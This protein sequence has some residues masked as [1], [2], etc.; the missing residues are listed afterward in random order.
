MG[1][2]YMDR[3]AGGGDIT[4]PHLTM[5]RQFAKVEQDENV[6][7]VFTMPQRSADERAAMFKAF[8]SCVTCQKSL[9]GQDDVKSCAKCE[10][11]RYC[12]TACQKRDAKHACLPCPELFKGISASFAQECELL[13]FLLPRIAQQPRADGRSSAP[14]AAFETL[15]EDILTSFGNVIYDGTLLIPEDAPDVNLHRDVQ[16]AVVPTFLRSFVDNVAFKKIITAVVD[17]ACTDKDRDDMIQSEERDPMAYYMQGLQ[18]THIAQL[19]DL[20][21]QH[22]AENYPDDEAMKLTAWKEVALFT[23]RCVAAFI[24]VDDPAEIVASGANMDTFAASLRSKYK[25]L[26]DPTLTADE[27]LKDGVRPASSVSVEEVVDL[28]SEASAFED[29]SDSSESE[30]MDAPTMPDV[31]AFKARSRAQYGGFVDNVGKVLAYL[32]KKKESKADQ[33]RARR[34]SLSSKYSDGPK[35]ITECMSLIAEWAKKEFKYVAFDVIGFVFVAFLRIGFT[36]LKVSTSHAAIWE[37]NTNI[38]NVIEPLGDTTPVVVGAYSEITREVDP[39]T[40]YGGSNRAEN[41]DKML[42]TVA[43][44]DARQLQDVINTPG[45][46]VASQDQLSHWFFSPKISSDAVIITTGT[47]VQTR[48]VRNNIAPAFAMTMTDLA[49][50][51]A[52][53]KVVF[54]KDV[55]LNPSFLYPTIMIMTIE[56][57]HAWMRLLLQCCFQ[58]RDASGDEDTLLIDQACRNVAMDIKNL[59]KMQPLRIQQEIEAKVYTQVLRDIY[60]EGE[61]LLTSETKLPFLKGMT[62]YSSNALIRTAIDDER[63]RLIGGTSQHGQLRQTQNFLLSGRETS[64]VSRMFTIINQVKNTI[65]RPRSFNG[66]NNSW[67]LRMHTLSAVFDYAVLPAAVSASVI[68]FAYGGTIEWTLF[69]LGLIAPITG[70]FGSTLK[71]YTAYLYGMYETVNMA[72]AIPA[73]VKKHSTAF[74]FIAY[75]GDNDIY[76][77]VIVICGFLGAVGLKWVM[78]KYW[79]SSKNEKRISA[80]LV[81]GGIKVV[82]KTIGLSHLFRFTNWVFNLI[83]QT[84]IVGHLIWAVGAAMALNYSGVFSPTG[85]S[86]WLGMSSDAVFLPAMNLVMNFS[87]LLALGAKDTWMYVP[88]L[89]AGTLK[90]AV[91]ALPAFKAN[92]PNDMLKQQQRRLLP[93][94]EKKKKKEEKE[95]LRSMPTDDVTIAEWDALAAD[96]VGTNALFIN[97]VC[98]FFDANIEGGGA[99]MRA[100][101]DDISIA[102]TDLLANAVEYQETGDESLLPD[103]RLS[104]VGPP[105]AVYVRFAEAARALAVGIS[106][107]INGQRLFKTDAD[108]PAEAVPISAAEQV[109]DRQKRELEDILMAAF[110][111]EEDDDTSEPTTFDGK[112]KKKK[113]PQNQEKLRNREKWQD[114]KDAIQVAAQ[115]TVVATS[116]WSSVKAFVM[117]TLAS[118]FV[119]QAAAVDASSIRQEMTIN[120][121]NVALLMDPQRVSGVLPGMSRIYDDVLRLDGGQTVFKSMGEPKTFADLTASFIRRVMGQQQTWIRRELITFSDDDQPLRELVNALLDKNDAAFAKA[122][123]DVATYLQNHSLARAIGKIIH[124][125]THAAFP[126]T[127]IN[128]TTPTNSHEPSAVVSALK[129]EA[130]KAAHQVNTQDAWLFF[131]KIA[132]LFDGSGDLG[133]SRGYALWKHTTDFLMVGRLRFSARYQALAQQGDWRPGQGRRLVLNAAVNMAPLVLA[134]FFNYLYGGTW[135]SNR[136]RNILALNSGV[137]IYTDFLAW[138][139][140]TRHRGAR[141]EKLMSME[142]FSAIHQFQIMHIKRLLPALTT[143]S[144]QAVTDN[145]LTGYSWA[146]ASGVGIVATSVASSYVCSRL[147][148]VIPD[149]YV[150]AESPILPQLAR[151]ALYTLPVLVTPTGFG[152][153]DPW[154]ITLKCLAAFFMSS[155]GSILNP[156]IAY[157]GFGVTMIAS[158]T[159]AP[160]LEPWGAALDAIRAKIFLE[161]Q[162][163][164]DF[165][166]KANRALKFERFLDQTEMDHECYVIA[167][168][169]RRQVANR[170]LTATAPVQTEVRSTTAPPPVP[171][172]SM[173]TPAQALIVQQPSSY[174]WWTYQDVKNTLSSIMPNWWSFW[175]STPTPVPSQYGPERVLRVMTPEEVRAGQLS[176]QERNRGLMNH[177]ESNKNKK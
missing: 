38:S 95:T 102:C 101:F 88:A 109:G 158:M 25:R 1:D 141:M 20:V 29:D 85:T 10:T 35:T 76:T 160:K 118:A 155:D 55:S 115:R 117:T 48:F 84:P 81:E 7:T 108:S 37:N 3:D 32:L 151:T 157:M 138:L 28:E 144:L 51:I 33:V 169:Y 56:S 119:G 71:K 104:A 142:N 89:A 91:D 154:T 12:S 21:E 127:K 100:L 52:V 31:E 166:A 163:S 107:P 93:T 15:D 70:L 132:K 68:S 165:I 14:T 58:S 77:A 159:Y 98:S 116:G 131:D 78:N 62:P 47:G 40:L 79:K 2:L 36:Y 153:P 174:D 110:M 73:F 66:R 148:R 65:S 103:P 173:T 136:D 170:T 133:V 86:G 23:R 150:N 72:I 82:G 145:D 164:A 9:R 123:T 45:V 61:D 46:T 34:D 177:A 83:T 16:A 26:F 171:P 137:H 113:K 130:E 60:E 167:E 43:V 63:I 124:K 105:P 146:L 114:P 112:E 54:Q 140:A 69:G 128:G 99:Q 172:V 22:A 161:R 41:I 59:G 50:I 176:E 67:A 57:A 8:F 121:T 125:I 92:G 175:S 19:I 42:S 97:A 106:Q 80:E 24:H 18:H 5:K 147:K 134:E 39:V 17:T 6:Q 156:D 53:M 126:E 143:I 11:R 152:V 44:A 49:S 122:K 94:L 111:S 96:A 90:L 13:R 135:F 149:F 87:I 75:M 30:Y 64:E 162:K 74:F 168:R 139:N 27:A 4:L 120:G 129:S